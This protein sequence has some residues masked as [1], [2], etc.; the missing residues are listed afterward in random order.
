M[1]PP[2]VDR[3]LPH[4]IANLVTI[5]YHNAVA[6]VIETELLSLSDARSIVRRGDAV[7]RGWGD[8]AIDTGDGGV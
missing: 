1:V 2:P 4:P 6:A 8:E 5:D 3:L 7:R